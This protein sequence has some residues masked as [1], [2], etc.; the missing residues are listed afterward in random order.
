MPDAPQQPA[1]SAP[2]KDPVIYTIPEQFYGAAAKAHLPRESVVAV[3]AILAAPAA[4]KAPAAAAPSG[5]T[6]KGGK[7]WIIIP[8]IAVLLIGGMAFAAWRYVQSLSRQTSPPVVT[9][10]AP[11]PEPEPQPEPEPEPEPT[12]QPEPATSTPETPPNPDLDGD[13]VKNSEEALY[14]TSPTNADSD[15]DGYADALE[16]ENLY[17]PAGFTPTKLV[18]ANLVETFSGQIDG[19]GP[20]IEFLY[21]ISAALAPGTQDGGWYVSWPDGALTQYVSIFISGRT[22]NSE[23][24]VIDMVAG[25]RPEYG[26]DRLIRF[27]TKS[28]LEGVRAPTGTPR[29]EAYFLID[30]ILYEVALSTSAPEGQHRH[31]STFT[32]LLN[33]FSKKP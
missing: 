25:L 12:P 13:G 27:V 1:A 29:G 31:E 20:E 5:P 26:R 24:T 3:P 7:G 22:E 9:P 4:A 2:K 32:M 15:A 33:S 6:K 23:A 11:E 19:A 8:I 18:E 10:P 17:N 28:G 16:I 21:P 30:G 14:G